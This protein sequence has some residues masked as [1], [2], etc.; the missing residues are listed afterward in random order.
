MVDPVAAGEHAGVRGGGARPAARPPG[1]QHQDRL[2]AR[3]RAGGGH[4]LAAVRDAL[5]V[6]QDRASARIGGE[7]IEHVAEIDI[8]HV[9]Q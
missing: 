1:L 5:D 8:G 2:Q 9:A 6:E 7:V 4:E 3:R